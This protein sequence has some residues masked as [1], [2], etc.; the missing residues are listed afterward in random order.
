[1]VSSKPVCS[2]TKENIQ[3]SNVDRKDLFEELSVTE[4]EER[5]E[6]ASRCLCRIGRDA[7]PTQPAG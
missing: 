7:A 6:L 2:Q 5:L 4:L 1:M 3:M